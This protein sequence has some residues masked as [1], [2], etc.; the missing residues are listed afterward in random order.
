MES[1]GPDRKFRVGGTGTN[2]RSWLFPAVRL[3]VFPEF[4]LGEADREME[5]PD[6]QRP[7]PLCSLEYHLLSELYGR[8]PVSRHTIRGRT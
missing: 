5:E 2:R 1:C 8:I 7:D 6:L 4:F 3:P